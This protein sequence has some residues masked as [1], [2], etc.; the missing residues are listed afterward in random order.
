MPF[1][2]YLRYPCII[3]RAQHILQ[4]PG[5]RC[6]CLLLLSLLSLAL[7]LASAR[8][9]RADVSAYVGYAENQRLPGYF[10]TP[11]LGSA[12]TLFLGTPGPNTGVPNNAPFWN[13]GAILLHNNG[14]G[15]VVLAPGAY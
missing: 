15:N 9:A 13:A 2:S 12:N 11:W 7:C 10:P 4:R 1:P 8:P 3:T 14:P 5:A 6:H